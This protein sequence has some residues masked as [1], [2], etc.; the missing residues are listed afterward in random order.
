VTESL[1]E[2][3]LRRL[4][5]NA[6]TEAT[7]DAG[8]VTREQ[9]SS[10]DLGFETRRLI[11]QSRGIWNPQ[12]L[13]ATL[14]VLS[15]PSGP[16]EDEAL[17]G[18][19][20]RYDY[21]AGSTDGDN[22]KLRRAFELDLP[23]ILLRKVGPK[24]FLPLFPVYVIADNFEERH[25]LLGLDES[26][27]SLSDPSNPTPLERR[28][29]KRLTKQR[30]HQPE[31]R[32]KV[33][34]A[35]DTRCAVCQLKHG[36]LLDAAHII[37]DADDGGDPVVT[38]GLTLCKIH[39]A[40]YDSNMMGISPDFTVHVNQDLL[41]EVDGPMLKHGIQEMDKRPLTLPLRRTDRPDRERLASRFESFLAS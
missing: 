21:R 15:T 40:S 18:S 20:F 37:G 25:F 13:Q 22:R 10:I 17:D 5:M 26:L 16:Y 31:F 33:L 11:D 6:L 34:L 8:T 35:Y 27:R 29:I 3:E 7:S 23:I 9:L 36:R 4:I 41:N 2:L 30:L 19:V 38:N 28:Y 32:A 24:A 39:H 1:G 14:S 12:D